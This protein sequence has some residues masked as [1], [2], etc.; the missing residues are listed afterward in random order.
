[1]RA[2]YIPRVIVHASSVRRLKQ[3]Q[4]TQQHQIVENGIMDDC[5]D[6]S[7]DWLDFL[8]DVVD[9]EA[10]CFEHPRETLQKGK[11]V[12]CYAES[13]CGH[14]RE[15]LQQNKI[16]RA[17]KRCLDMFGEIVEN[18]KDDYLKF[19][20]HFDR[21]SKHGII[22]HSI[23]SLRLLNLM[24]FPSTRSADMK[25]SIKD[26]VERNFGQDEIVYCAEKYIMEMTKKSEGTSRD[27][28]VEVLVTENNG[29]EEMMDT[30]E[31]YKEWKVIALDDE[32]NTEDRDAEETEGEGRER[33]VKKGMVSL[34][35]LRDAE[36]D[37]K[38]T[39]AHFS[40][41]TE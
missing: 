13:S 3:K 9:Y 39:E 7:G 35:M 36:E 15:T 41:E 12:L 29:D 21:S 19:Y 10:S 11:I 18:S 30:I 6:F 26:H 14:P 20:K 1:M 25:I 16:L 2:I 33:T 8:C 28:E 17:I 24:R 5:E 38:T 27:W 40:R 4:N 37:M 32:G 31:A 22:E 23:F 34:G